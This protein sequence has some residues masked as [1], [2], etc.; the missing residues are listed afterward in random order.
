MN[1]WAELL[2]TGIIPL[3]TLSLDSAI[4]SYRVNKVDFITTL[5]SL[6]TLFKYET[7]YYRLLA[8]HQKN[9]AEIE[10]AGLRVEYVEIVD[11]EEMQP[12][13]E[14]R[15]PVRI[16]AAA[17]LGATRLIDNLPLR[18]DGTWDLGVTNKD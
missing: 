1:S 13:E 18:A 6:M 10:A 7:Q 5:D 3:A 14:I 12:V 17:W 2:K 4:S 9:I 15:K 11:P 8:D 16:A